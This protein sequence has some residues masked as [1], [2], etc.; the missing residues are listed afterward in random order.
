MSLENIL[1]RLLSNKP[2]PQSA[3]ILIKIAAL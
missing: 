1:H 3:A 2:T